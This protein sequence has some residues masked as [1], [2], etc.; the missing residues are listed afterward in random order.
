MALLDITSRQ[1]NE[2]I[3]LVVASV[4]AMILAGCHANTGHTLATSD[5]LAIESDRDWTITWTLTA[6]KARREL[7]DRIRDAIWNYRIDGGTWQQTEFLIV[8]VDAATVEMKTNVPREKLAHA[9]AIEAYPVYVF[10][11]NTEGTERASTPRKITI[12]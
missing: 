11:G 12:K 2:V 8:Q 10:D 7:P 4:T 6:P 9:T 1:K 5:P 3:K